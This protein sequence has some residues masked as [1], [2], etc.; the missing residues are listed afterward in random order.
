MIEQ[1]VVGLTVHN[2]ML[3]IIVAPLL[4]V[5]VCM[6]DSVFNIQPLETT[7]VYHSRLLVVP[8]D[9]LYAFISS[10][11]GHAVIGGQCGCAPLVC[12]DICMVQ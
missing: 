11:D 8:L 1:R 9:R 12:V 6:M 7:E 5:C 2:D 10:C 4:C 3:I